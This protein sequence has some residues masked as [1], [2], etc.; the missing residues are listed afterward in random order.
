MASLHVRNVDDDVVERL[1]ARAS[2]N[3]RSA[4]AEHRAILK[5]ALVWDE[6]PRVDIEDWQRRAAAFRESLKDRVHTPSEVLLRES[7]D[8]R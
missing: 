1:K 2:Q 8:E 4:E 6:R 3:G 5:A 7:R